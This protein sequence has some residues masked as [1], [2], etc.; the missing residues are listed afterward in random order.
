M[1]NSW[2]DR[3]FRRS[4]WEADEPLRDDLEEVL[5]ASRPVPPDL[6]AG[7]ANSILAHALAD[8]RTPVRRGPRNVTLVAVFAMAGCV[9]AVGLLL[10][11][12]MSGSRSETASNVP[13]SQRGKKWL[14]KATL[15]PLEPDNKRRILPAGGV[16]RARQLE[17]KRIRHRRKAMQRIW[18]LKPVRL[19]PATISARDVRPRVVSSDEKPDVSPGVV[20]SGGEGH[21]VL[22]VTGA[23]DPRPVV[24]IATG[25]Q[26][27]AGFAKAS[28]YRAVG[29]GGGVL[30]QCTIRDDAENSEVSTTQYGIVYDQPTMRL[31]VE[32]E[33][34]SEEPIDNERGLR[35]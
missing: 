27:P 3:I 5:R 31:P 6:P 25:V 16:P 10:A 23:A 15:V 21:L 8:A 1:W 13:G 35:P 2:W 26:T 4:R 19:H 34:T 32:V 20:P 29:P 22:I 30:T 17:V 12:Q 24:E 28:S 9:L 33:H 18:A 14:A 7:T 11:R